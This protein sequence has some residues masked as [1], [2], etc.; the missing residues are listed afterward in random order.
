METQFLP[1]VYP[2]DRHHPLPT[3]LTTDP[4]RINFE[5]EIRD[6]PA[7]STFSSV[8]I[9]MQRIDMRKRT[10]DCVEIN[11]HSL[12]RC[13]SKEIFGT[14]KHVDLL[15]EKLCNEF[16]NNVESYIYF[17]GGTII[18]AYEESG[19]KIQNN[20][21]SNEKL[22]KLVK[23]RIEDDLPCDD[24]LLWLACTFFQTTIFVLRVTDT[25]TLTESFW[26]DYSMVRKRRK[27]PTKRTSFSR[28]CPDEKTYY[29]TL[30]ESGSK[31]NYRIV[32]KQASC[33]CA[34]DA[35]AVPDHN[36]DATEYHTFQGRSYCAI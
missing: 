26:T 31:L 20:R 10:I 15:I 21:T 27:D 35:P 4:E 18:K 2:D 24:L 8:R 7:C 34:L 30:F 11:H 22:A 5:M 25:N 9:A 14:E 17:L 32:P 28:R 16:S 13:L 3:F 19:G 6:F 23:E 1:C 33:N 12:L 36:A 29:I